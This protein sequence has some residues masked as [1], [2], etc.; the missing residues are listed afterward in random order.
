MTALLITLGIATLYDVT[1]TTHSRWARSAWI[2]GALLLVA[3][4]CTPAASSSASSSG[5]VAAAHCQHNRDTLRCV[6]VLK[7]YDGDT[8]T[9]DVP[10]VHPLL[11]EKV[12][13][14]VYGIDTAEV[15]GHGPCE[16]DAARVARNLVAAT[17]RDA[18]Q[19]DL[20]N[21]QRDKYFRILA[22]VVVDGR[23]LSEILIKN[24]L[25]VAYDGGTKQA[26]NWCAALR[27]PAA[28]G[29]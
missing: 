16:K 14:R 15:R 3:T 25:A 27:R 29:R 10:G 6:K 22:D 12:S 9:V 26:T 1:L 11:G 24:G 19:V 7:N 4:A 8:I 17:L 5:G 2:S 21:V 23:S 28:S 13:V 20:R 18:K